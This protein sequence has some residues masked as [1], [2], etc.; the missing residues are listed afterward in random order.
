MKKKEQVETK[1]IGYY[2]RLRVTAT[3]AVV[4]IHVAMGLPNNYGIAELGVFPFAI[5]NSTYL[6]VNWAVPI[7]IAI[8]GA[9]LLTPQKNI[10]L[11]KI[12]AYI[13]RMFFVLFTFGGVFA[14]IELSVERRSFS[15]SVIFK[16][17]LNMLQGN[18]WSHMWYIYM[19]I[20]LYM[21][22]IPLRYIVINMD[23]KELRILIA[24][25]IVG[26]FV[27]PTI[28]V[29]LDI[30][31]ETYM[32]WSHYLTYYLLGYYMS[33]IS[34]ENLASCKRWF[35]PAIAIGISTFKFIVEYIWINQYGKICPLVHS[36]RIWVLLQ[37]VSI[38]MSY[39]LFAMKACEKGQI[40]P[41]IKNIGRCSFAIYLIHPVFEN[42]FYKVIGFTPLSMP[43]GLGMIVM[44][45]LLFGLSWIAAQLMIRVPIVKNYI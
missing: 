34:D 32:Q 45:I 27:I 3:I 4:I 14:I 40:N 21:V 2:E 20:G 23:R 10:D 12:C 6:L 39:R 26:N 29:S 13:K 41:I 17:Y 36:G 9:L 8:T 38:F 5:M 31:L 30:E 15:L 19:L 16:G 18:S 1:R 42:F 37:M 33:T 25:L 44:T 22:T 35:F 11:K 43:I 28:N 24:T 7:F